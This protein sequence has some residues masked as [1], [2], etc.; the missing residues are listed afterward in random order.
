MSFVAAAAIGAGGALVGGYLAGQGAQRG[1]DTQAAAM[2]EAAALNKQMFDVQNAQQAPYREAGYS[3]LS[4]ITAMK[5]YL[6]QQFGPEQFAAG[7][8]PGYAFRLQQGNLA[9]LNLANQ[10]G[11]AISGNTLTGLLNYGQGAASQ[12]FQNAFNRFQ[13]GRG[14]IFNNLASIASLG[15]TSLGQ[16][17]QLSSNTAQNVGNAIAGAGSAIGA[18]QVAT[19]NA[20]GNALQGAGNQYMLSQILSQR[21]PMTPTGGVTPTPMTPSAPSFDP[22]QRFSYGNVA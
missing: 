20:Y 5:P 4:D 18:G 22:Y 7:I 17:G 1:A 2:R 14:N 6:T 19:G 10:S 3:A 8:D 12:E 15:Q 11:G 21:N 9:N 13:T 16:T